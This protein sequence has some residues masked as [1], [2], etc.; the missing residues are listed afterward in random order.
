MAVLKIKDKYGVW[1]N[2]PSLK[3]KD[4]I[5]ENGGVL[6]YKD[7]YGAWRRVSVCGTAFNYNSNDDDYPTISTLT[8]GSSVYVNENGTPAEYLVVHQGLPDIT[9]YDS[10]CDGVWLLR[11]DIYEQRAWNTSANN[12]YSESSIHE[13]LN[14]TYIG[15]FDSGIQTL[16]KQAKI[17][18]GAGGGT[19]TVKSGVNGVSAKVFLPS[20]VEVGLYSPS[21]YPIDGACLSYFN[22]ASN[23]LRVARLNGTI[24]YWWLRS[25]DVNNNGVWT[26]IGTGATKYSYSAVAIYGVRPMLI[27]PYTAK[28]DTNTNTIIS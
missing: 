28:I 15:M 16:I 6:K 11:K 17:P 10:S 9:L 4:I 23:S 24:S 3:Y 18:Y 25:P 13:Y 1:H 12:N 8:V 20:A 2:A 7:Q 14:G 19:T 21:D 22:G 27:L 5:W 26:I